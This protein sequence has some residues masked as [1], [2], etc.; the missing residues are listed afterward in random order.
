MVGVPMLCSHLSLS[1]F[2]SDMTCLSHHKTVT[3]GAPHDRY[4]VH[5]AAVPS[6]GVLDF[7][8]VTL[9]AF[10]QLVPPFET[11]FQ[12]YM[13]A[14]RMNGKPRT[15]RR[16]TVDKNCPL[17]TPEDRLSFI[18]TYVKTSTLHVVQGRLFGMVQSKANRWIHVLLPALLAALRVLGDAPP[19]FLT[20]LA[21]WLGIPEAYAATWVTPLEETLAPV[22]GAPA[23]TPEPPPFAH[24]GTERRIVRPHNAAAQ[25]ASHNAPAKRGA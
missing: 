18:L 1:R 11:A 16:F 6:D 12:C 8:S 22:V 4:T 20:A 19:H 3:R 25:K 14:W 23:T 17:P 2:L 21:Q 24:D 13:A 15:T 7:T 9:D 5:R 10:Q